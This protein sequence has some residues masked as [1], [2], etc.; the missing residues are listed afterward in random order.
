MTWADI[1]SSQTYVLTLRQSMEQVFKSWNHFA[2][3]LSDADK[4]KDITP[5]RIQEALQDR[6]GIL[7]DTEKGLFG[8][9]SW[10][11][12]V[13]DIVNHPTKYKF[14]SVKEATGYITDTFEKLISW[15][16]LL[17]A[18]YKPLFAAFLNRSPYSSSLP[19]GYSLPEGGIDGGKNLAI[20]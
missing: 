1:Q 19:E 5:M 8:T 16:N 13:Q 7:F 9:N 2:Q 12:H 14:D 3:I 6:F 20:K 15:Y 4:G 10:L 17:D 18:R 11:A